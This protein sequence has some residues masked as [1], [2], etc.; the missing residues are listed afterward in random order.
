MRPKVKL[1]VAV[2]GEAYIERFM[3]LALP[4]A[5]APENLP[6][7]AAGAE[8]EVL[9]MTTSDGARYFEGKRAYLNLGRICRV[10]FLAIDDLIGSSAY[11]VTLTLAYMR[12]IA[13]VGEDMVNTHFVFLNSDFVL[14]DGS[15]RTLLRC[16]LEGRHCVLAPSF[17]AVAEDVEPVLEQGVDPAATTLAM[18]PREMVR[19]ALRHLH[20]TSMARMVNQHLVRSTHPN[21]LYWH[22]DKNTLVGRFY[23]IFMLC[24][25]PERVVRTINSY[26]DYGFVPE[27]CPSGNVTILTDSDDFFMLETQGRTQEL[28]HLQLGTLDPTAIALSLSEWTTRGHRL[29]ASHD[30][31]FHSEDLPPGLDATKAEAERYVAG[32]SR[33]LRPPKDHAFHYHWVSGVEV[34]REQLRLLGRPGVAPEITQ[35]PADGPSGISH[36]QRFVRLVRAAVIGT[37]PFVRIWHH[38]WSDYRLIQRNIRKISSGGA[39]R[40]LF[41]GDARSPVAALFPTEGPKITRASGR[42]IESVSDI[43]SR[44]GETFDGI[45]CMLTPR[46]LLAV[47]GEAIEQVLEALREGGTLA[48][49]MHRTGTDREVPDITEDLLTLLARLPFDLLGSSSIAFCGGVVREEMRKQFIRLSKAFYRRGPKS[50]LELAPGLAGVFAVNLLNNIYTSWVRD[51]HAFAPYCSTLIIRLAR[52][53]KK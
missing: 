42:G 50:A 32:L 53:V 36:Q 31:M 14:A 10:R 45:V 26:C 25:K 8:L 7:L 9:V 2:W 15:L 5:L 18:K 13:S 38:D 40:I 6:A 12:G 33:L 44:A 23:L 39:E 46:D 48:L 17:R 3:A 21:Q 1:V 29:A 28:D 49:V 22:V 37:R 4:S 43:I 47:R 35:P 20:P 41:V 16:I 52:Q 11:G 24:I 30:L 34:W 51:D 19:L 27:F